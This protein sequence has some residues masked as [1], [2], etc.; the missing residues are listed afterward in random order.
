LV[1]IRNSRKN[2]YRSKN[3]VHFEV[4]GINDKTI[5]NKEKAIDSLLSL[6]RQTNRK[7]Q[8][9]TRIVP[10]TLYKR[11]TEQLGRIA[12]SSIVCIE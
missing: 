4:L 6:D 3:I 5:G 12:T 8:L 11:K 7:D 1:R 2:D 9:G 10:K